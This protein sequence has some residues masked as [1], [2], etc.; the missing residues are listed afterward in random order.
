MPWELL[1]TSWNTAPLPIPR[2]PWAY[3]VAMI[4][5]VVLGHRTYLQ[6]SLACWR[7]ASSIFVGPGVN[8]WRRSDPFQRGSGTSEETDLTGRV[9]GGGDSLAVMVATF[10]I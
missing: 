2:F 7:F 8:P 5:S 6:R 4:A 3:F 10:I 1:G 9:T